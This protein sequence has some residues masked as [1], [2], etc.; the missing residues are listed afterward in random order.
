MKMTS[1]LLSITAMLFASCSAERTERKPVPAQGS[2]GGSGDATAANTGSNGGTAAGGGTVGSGG[3]GQTVPLAKSLEQCTTERKAWRAVVDSGAT[4]SD[5]IETL[6]N[7]C[8]TRPE[9]LKRFPTIAN[10]IDTKF[11][12]LIDQQ[13]YVLYHCSFDGAGRYTFHLGNIKAGVTNYK[14]V[15]VSGISPVN[16][17]PASECPAV[18]TEMLKLP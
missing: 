5:C 14:V 2:D 13:K 3:G 12:D 18:T 8:C 4:P 17:P 6:V 16:Q 11:K 9:I 15:Y 7:W 1:F 10:V